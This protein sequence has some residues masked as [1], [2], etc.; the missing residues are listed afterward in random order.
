MP[1]AGHTT[2]DILMNMEKCKKIASHNQQAVIPS[3]YISQHD[4]HLVCNRMT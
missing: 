4:A 3:A 2:P 1:K